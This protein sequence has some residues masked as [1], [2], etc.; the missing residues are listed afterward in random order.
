MGY[1]EMFEDAHK[2]GINKLA[3]GL[4]IVVNAALIACCFVPF[5]E[6]SAANTLNVEK[7]DSILIN[8]DLSDY[9]KPKVIPQEIK[10]PIRR[11]EAK[12]ERF[13]N[14]PEKPEIKPAP[15][16]PAPKP[17]PHVPEPEAA[18]PNPTPAPAPVVSK[19]LITSTAPDAPR[20]VSGNSENN[21]TSDIKA[22]P[23]GKGNGKGLGTGT[24]NESNNGTATG[25]T[26]TGTGSAPFTGLMYRKVISRPSMTV[27]SE[28]E[29]KV[30]VEVCV[31]RLGKVIDATIK[32]KNTT[33]TD[34]SLIERSLSYARQYK[35][36]AK[37][38]APER[39][40]GYIS[41]IY[42]SRWM[43]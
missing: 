36:E 21:T 3:V 38:D 13:A 2:S 10:Q 5:S 31:D 26:G 27:R 35:Y 12:P 34:A 15:L 17:K 25:G 14:L 40:C 11:M 43:K 32:T 28:L 18:K 33:A 8:V 30:V 37:E 20:L 41:F 6:N 29:G 7:Q 23:D 16:A 39:Q 1:S 24:G 19:P 42:E 4:S 22:S 9:Q